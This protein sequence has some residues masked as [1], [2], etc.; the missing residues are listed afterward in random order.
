MKYFVGQG[1][2]LK[3]CEAAFSH[4]PILLIVLAACTTATTCRQTDTHTRSVEAAGR[5]KQEG[6]G[7]EGGLVERANKRTVA[8]TKRNNRNYKGLD[9]K[10]FCDLWPLAIAPC[11]LDFEC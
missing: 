1:I 3:G 7:V 9:G 2:Q 4:V 5:S 6:C 10:A 8:V 11:Y